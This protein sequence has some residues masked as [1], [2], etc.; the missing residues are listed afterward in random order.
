[1]TVEP[2]SRNADQVVAAA[3]ADTSTRA[4]WDGP[5]YVLALS[6]CSDASR[7]HSGRLAA[8]IVRR[9]DSAGLIGLVGTYLRGAKEALHIDE[10]TTAVNAVVVASG[11]VI[12]V[13]ADVLWRGLRWASEKGEVDAGALGALVR[14]IDGPFREAYLVSASG[15]NTLGEAAERELWREGWWPVL[16]G[17]DVSDA[18]FE[19]LMDK[20]H[21]RELEIDSLIGV[22]NS[23]RRMTAIL[24]MAEELGA[25]ISDD[26]ARHHYRW[27]IKEPAI[28]RAVLVRGGCVG[29][30]LFSYSRRD[31]GLPAW[32][33]SGWL[34]GLPGRARE[35]VARLITQVGGP[36]TGAT[37][38]CDEAMMRLVL[39]HVR[40]AANSVAGG[41]PQ[42]GEYAS[43]LLEALLT[44]LFGEDRE[45]ARGLLNP[46]TNLVELADVVG[47]L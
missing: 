6:R 35:S 8:V 33:D 46:A 13:R 43:T 42:G 14:S 3:K 26:Y 11:R 5:R 36:G 17:F 15:M 28:L 4:E 45:V 27:L 23:A 12:S 39:S 2:L 1:M 24:E 19:Y 22:T 25:E 31:E 30:A 20:V 44:E 37:W 38:S 7:W 34:A 40:G 18:T 29:E 9:V 16:T 21:A 10:L 47:R 41:P 32:A